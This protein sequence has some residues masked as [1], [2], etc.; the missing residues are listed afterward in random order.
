[1]PFADA[2]L[3]LIFV[4]FGLLLA[5]MELFL[6]ID[7]GLDFVII[8]S[9]LVVGGLAGWAFHSWE[10]A[11]VMTSVAGIAYLTL[12][13]RYVHRWTAVRQQKTNIDAIIGAEG[14]ALKSIARNSDGLV[15][16]G[17]EEWRARAEE[18]I[19]PSEEIIVKSVSGVTL[20]VE[21]KGKG[22]D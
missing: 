8:G 12:G 9:A 6:G 16:V 15:R 1:M 20:N 13:R 17:N 4:I 14:V 11:V 5:I 18:N 10:L 21:K 3:W 7:A 2:W 19:E 22:G